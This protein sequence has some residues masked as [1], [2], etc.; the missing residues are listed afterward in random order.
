M[1][2]TIGQN[3]IQLDETAF[4]ILLA[5]QIGRTD[6]AFYRNELKPAA[7]YL[8][9]AGPKTPQERWEET[10]G[11]STSTLASQIAALAAAGDIAEKNGDAEDRRRS[12]APL[13]M[14]GSAAPRNGCSPPMARWA[15]ESTTCVS[16]PRAARTTAPP[17]TGATAPESTPENAV[18]DGGFLEFVRLGI[19]APADPYVADS[20]AET[21]ASISQETPGGR[22][23]HRYTLDGYGEKADGSPWDG[24]G[25]GRLW[26]LLSGERGE[27]AL[28]NGQDAVPYLQTMHSAANAGY[29]IPEQVWDR[30]E[31]TSYGHELGR[32]TGSASPLSWAMA[33]YVRLAAGV[34]AGSP[35]ETPAGMSLHAT[36]AGVRLSSPE[37]TCYRPEALTTAD[38]ATAVVRGTTNAAKVYVSVNGT[39]TE[40]PGN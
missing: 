39:A 14:N 3:G 19:K 28:A 11:Y 10:G 37:L 18:L 15:T 25:I 21:D 22:M 27:Y 38:S 9:G 8:V 16:A 12:T 33:Q 2:G 1:D 13:R 36:Q 6:A 32:S 35:V 24:T 31:P 34:K 4:P 26:P 40:A 20:L 29:M 23:W 30:D 7:D 17:V 5:N